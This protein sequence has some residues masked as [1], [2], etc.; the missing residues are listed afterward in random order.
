MK[1]FLT[2][3]RF[4]EKDRTGFVWKRTLSEGKRGATFQRF[5]KIKMIKM[6]MKI[7]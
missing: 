4:G 3:V 2:W 6:T 7:I 1:P 5:K